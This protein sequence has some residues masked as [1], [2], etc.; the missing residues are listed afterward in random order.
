MIL[1]L[2][3]EY[4]R[5]VGISVGYISLHRVH[6]WTPTKKITKVRLEVFTVVTVQNAVFWDVTP[7]GCCQVS[8]PSSGW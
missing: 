3:N 5:N 4:K 1:K 2:E 6:W 8:L 7:C